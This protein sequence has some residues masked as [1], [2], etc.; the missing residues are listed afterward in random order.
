MHA[1]PLNHQNYSGQTWYIK[2]KMLGPSLYNTLLHDIKLSQKLPRMVSKA[3]GPFTRARS[4]EL[5]KIITH[6]MVEHTDIN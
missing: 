2:P 6:D 1:T 5:F 4:L 3:N